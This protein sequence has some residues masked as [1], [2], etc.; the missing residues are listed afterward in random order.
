MGSASFTSPTRHCSCICCSICCNS[1]STAAMRLCRSC[2]SS[3]NLLCSA[4]VRGKPPAKNTAPTSKT[5][6]VTHGD[7][8]C[9]L[10]HCPNHCS[11][12][13]PNSCP[14]S[15]SGPKKNG[16]ASPTRPQAQSTPPNTMKN[17]FFAT[18]GGIRLT[19]SCFICARRSFSRESVVCKC[20]KVRN[21]L[22]RTSTFSR[23]VSALP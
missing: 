9:I 6:P 8:N 21:A 3:A 10:C 18:C 15:C 13:G 2:V 11:G 17:V 14:N 22:A 20:R 12:N 16:K 4:P 1:C 23:D 7:K 5:A 19:S